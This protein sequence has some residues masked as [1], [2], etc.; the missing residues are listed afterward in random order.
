M[1]L[2]Q[3]RSQSKQFYDLEQEFLRNPLRFSFEN[4][5]KK[6]V[7]QKKDAI[8]PKWK[9]V[10]EQLLEVLTIANERVKNIRKL[11]SNGLTRGETDIFE[12]IWIEKIHNQKKLS[13]SALT[14]IL[15]EYQN[16][17]SL[18]PRLKNAVYTCNVNFFKEIFDN[19]ILQFATKLRH[20]LKEPKNE[21]NVRR[22]TDIIEKLKNL[23]DID[24]NRVKKFKAGYEPGYNEY[25]I[26]RTIIY[27]KIKNIT[28]N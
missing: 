4:E 11:V 7:R 18:I 28:N 12:K 26:A 15:K 14:S 3:I 23:P 10:L 5:T 22:K 8:G 2:D 16:L 9:K 20:L 6:A 13:P 1:T 24:D 25:F 17:N 21:N 19:D 27:N